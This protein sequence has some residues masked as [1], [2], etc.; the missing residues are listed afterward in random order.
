MK[1]YQGE[2][3]P[4][5]PEIARQV[6]EAAGWRCVRCRHPHD[7]ESGHTL[8]V[9]HLDDDKSNVRWYNLPALCQRCHLHIQG[10]VSMHRVWIFEHSD[11]FQ[12]YVA[13]FYAWKY[14]GLQLSREEVEADLDYYVSLEGRWMRGESLEEEA[15]SNG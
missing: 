8:T 7:P 9:H 4:D 12:P 5:W 3:P 6:K 13:G 10:K 14:L 2:Y 1:Q 11:W 15:Q